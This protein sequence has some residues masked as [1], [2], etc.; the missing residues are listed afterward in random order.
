MRAHT[1]K[2]ATDADQYKLL[3]E[4]VLRTNGEC[5][6][7]HRFSELLLSGFLLAWFVCGN[8]WVF[9]VWLPNFDQQLHA[10]SLW[11]NRT[12]YVLAAVHIFACHAFILVVTKKI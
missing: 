4:T 9:G 2:H 11:C 7:S 5:G 3:P 12:V 1:V 6:C 8:C 10:P